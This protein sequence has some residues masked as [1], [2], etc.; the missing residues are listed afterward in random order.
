[1]KRPW[2]GS[3]CAR[4]LAAGTLVGAEVRVG[5]DEPGVSGDAQAGQK[6]LPS[7]ASFEQAGHRLTFAE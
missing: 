1:M 7:G 6:R 4:R 3:E 2:P 5:V